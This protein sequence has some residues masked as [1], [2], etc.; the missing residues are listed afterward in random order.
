MRVE[1]AWQRVPFK[2]WQWV[3]WGGPG[4]WILALP[5]PLRVSLKAWH[6]CLSIKRVVTTCLIGRLWD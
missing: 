6:Q 1:I 5:L 2:E 3:E 4:L